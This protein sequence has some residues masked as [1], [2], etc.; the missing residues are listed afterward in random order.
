[1][2]NP[3]NARQVAR[4]VA[5]LRHPLLAAGLELVDTPGTGSVYEHNSDEARSAIQD[6]DLAVF[7]TSAVPPVSASERAFLHDVRDLAVRTLVVLSKIDLLE[8]E[9]LAAV[10]EFT[11]GT[12]GQ[13]LGRPVHVHALSARQ[14][15]AAR[16]SV[17]A[18]RLAASGLPDLE[19]VLARA[20][21][22]RL[23]LLR[24]SVAAQAARFAAAA[25]ADAEL[26]TRAAKLDAADLARR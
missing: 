23:D 14:A 11:S 18:D 13:A 22:E 16:R 21:A 5:R 4:V 19:R 10:A 17:D 12:V 2:G 6:M 7:I 26:T 8:A 9:E 24:A 1:V 15:Q 25:A 20:A 3:H